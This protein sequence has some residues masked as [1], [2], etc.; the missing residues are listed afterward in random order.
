[1][2]KF[3]GKQRDAETGY[4]YFGARYY[5]PR[6]GNWGSPDPLF[7]KHIQ[8]T[9]YNYVLRN[10]MVLI[11]PDGMQI[12]SSFGLYLASQQLLSDTKPNTQILNSYLSSEMPKER[13]DKFPTKSSSE[14][15]VEQTGDEMLV[16]GPVTSAL[17]EISL[18]KAGTKIIADEIG[19]SIGKTETFLI[20]EESKQISEKYYVQLEKQFAKDGE[21]SILK[22]LEKTEKVLEK[23]LKKVN[24]VEFNSSIKREINTFEKQKNT[25][26]K[27]IKDKGFGL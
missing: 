16:A 10:P 6:Y 14:D 2:Y 26:I 21:K 3:T 12:N 4:D 18:G 23:H 5:I 13:M 27:F 8:W 11:D 19:T 7:E 1:M 17:K 20:K 15:A 25:L 24:S 22:S 9:P